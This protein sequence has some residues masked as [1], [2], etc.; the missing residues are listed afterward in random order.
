MTETTE[1]T[2]D[3]I[4]ETPEKTGEEPL[5]D[6]PL[7]QGPV[8]DGLSTDEPEQEKKTFP[9]LTVSICFIVLVAAVV[10]AVPS[11]RRK[12]VAVYNDKIAA[13]FEKKAVA[14]LSD[15][16]SVPVDLDNVTVVEEIDIVPEQDDVKELKDRVEQL[17][18]ARD[19]ENADEIIA[20]TEP[21]V[22][23]TVAQIKELNEKIDALTARIRELDRQTALFE[24]EK[25][26]KEFVA[27]LAARVRDTERKVG[28]SS[29]EKQKKAALLMALT[30]LQRAVYEG[31]SFLTQEQALETLVSP[32][33]L[34]NKKM[35]PLKAYA[36]TGVMTPA[37]LQEAFPEYARRLV[38]QSG[39]D[40]N[41]CW[42]KKALTSLKGLVVVRRLDAPV[43]DTSTTAVLARAEIAVENGEFQTAVS[44][45]KN[46][47][48]KDVGFVIPWISNAERM[49][50]V[51][52]ALDEMTAVILSEKPAR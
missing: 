1:K 6:E 26:D 16:A 10:G 44:E 52:N 51:H 48:N 50:L 34:L 20:T 45:L 2:K 17:E 19:F 42:M 22:V 39:T 25:A 12:A 5:K 24:R 33:S 4:Q 47:N 21:P 9:F 7:A 49:I 11:L 13:R 15:V 27:A 3:E 18:N 36:E 38:R 29:A 8:T 14:D 31:K 40:A 30:Q 46:L 43:D 41:D 35:I 28:A 23:D 37:A 32:A